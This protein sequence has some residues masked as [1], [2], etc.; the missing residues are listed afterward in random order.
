MMTELSARENLLRALRHDNPAHTPYEG[1]GA[2]RIVDHRGRKP[3]RAG[4]DEWG[5][6]WTPLPAGYQAGRDEPLESYPVK[7]AAECAAGLNLDAFPDGREAGLFDGVL[8]GIEP[9]TVLIIGR[10]GAGPLDR[11]CA[12][13]GMPGALAAMLMESNETQAAL[14]RIADY[15]VEIARGY[16][17]AGVDAGFLADDYAGQDG[18][19]LRPAVWRRMILPGLQRIIAIYRDAGA[20]VVFHTCGRA[21]AFIGDLIEAGVTAFNLQSAACDLAALK[22]AY[23]RRIGFYGGIGS[24]VMQAGGPADVEAATRQALIAL[25]SDG[26]LMLA[27]DQPLDYPA[28]NLEALANAARRYG[29]YPLQG[30]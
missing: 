10:H 7:Y 6:T 24:R 1:E 25:G 26:G 13:L 8:D 9:G 30:K 17:A 11:L 4:V 27:P 29:R 19:Y 15:H 5:V 3:P 23:G 2:W 18:P 21:E 20:P 12:L 22:A 28:E 14:D 16:L